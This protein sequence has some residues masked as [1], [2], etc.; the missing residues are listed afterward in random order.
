M[1]MAEIQ[2]KINHEDNTSEGEFTNLPDI[3]LGNDGGERPCPVCDHGNL[4][5]DYFLNLCCDN[6]GYVEASCFT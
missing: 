1:I 2:K 4:K 5:Y 3:D 6:C